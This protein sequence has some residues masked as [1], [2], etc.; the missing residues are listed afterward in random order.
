M[1]GLRFTR[2]QILAHLGAL[3]PMAWL[4]LDYFQG[5]FSVNPIQDITLRTG[6]AALVLLV[7]SL[8]C[9]P[10][11][12]YFGWRQALSIRRA[13]G[14]YAFGYAFIHFLI[15]IGLDYAFDWALLWLEIVEKPYIWVGST[16]LSILFLLAITSTNGW[17][18]RL[19][20]GWKQLHRLVYPAALLVIVH[21]AWVKKGDILAL[22]GDVIQPLLFGLVVVTL[23]VAR[24]APVKKWFFRMRD[25]SSRKPAESQSS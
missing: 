25:R 15:F 4:W 2:L 20:K 13:L 16:A 12:T 21:F 7:L 19:G 6:K 5:N 22:Q 3:L 8:A 9:T 18:K 14:L 10:A 24:T 23:L 11:N 1:A 17:K